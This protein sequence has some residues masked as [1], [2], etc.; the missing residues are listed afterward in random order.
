ML[1]E[2]KSNS[3]LFIL[4]PILFQFGHE[5]LFP[6]VLV[7]F[8]KPPF[9]VD[10]FSSLPYFLVPQDAPAPV[11]SVISSPRIPGSLYWEYY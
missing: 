6:S 1:T 9:R 5:E 10:L 11:Q 7:S 2:L 8:D 4:L 3:T